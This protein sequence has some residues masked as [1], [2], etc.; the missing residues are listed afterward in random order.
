MRNFEKSQ[1][2]HFVETFSI[3]LVIKC[4]WRWL[5]VFKRKDFFDKRSVYQCSEMSS[6]ILTIYTSK[7]KLSQEEV[8]CP[9]MWLKLVMDA[10]SPTFFCRVFT[11]ISNQFNH[12]N[13]IPSKLN[14]PL[15][16]HLDI[17]FV[18]YVQNQWLNDFSIFTLIPGNCFENILSIFCFVSMFYQGKTRSMRFFHF[19][20][21]F[22]HMF[23]FPC[24]INAQ[25]TR[26]TI[27]TSFLLAVTNDLHNVFEQMWQRE[28]SKQIITWLSSYA[29]Q[30]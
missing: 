23:I 3:S 25:L 10:Q 6:K 11:S 27:K 2:R 14:L 30:S 13:D 4:C 5:F 15:F 16:A 24:F 20:V 7:R 19:H 21:I 12:D 22:I 17:L 18:C 1:L 9:A 28:K 26:W 29:L 8:T